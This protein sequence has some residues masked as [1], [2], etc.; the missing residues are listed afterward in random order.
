[1]ARRP[2]NLR[3][4]LTG[5]TLV[6]CSLALIGGGAFAAVAAAGGTYVDL[7]AHGRYAGDRY[8][9]ATDSTDWRTT[10]F[11]WAGSVRLRVAP[12]DGKAIFVGVAAP[13]ALGRYLSG[14]GYTTITE[15][16]GGVVRT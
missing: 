5:V 10:W 1:M 6:A 8:A 11:G 7:G 4:L 14:A 12:D 9:L 13:A 2:R 3:G 16:H 15:H